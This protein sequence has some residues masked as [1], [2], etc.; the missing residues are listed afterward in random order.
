MMTERTMVNK[1]TLLTAVRPGQPVR[2][3]QVNGAQ[4]F[5]ARLCAMGLTPGAPVE[6]ACFS[7]GPVIANVMGGQ[8]MLG[9]GITAKVLVQEARA[10]PTES[11]FSFLGRNVRHAEPCATERTHR[12]D[13]PGR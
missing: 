12:R 4:R 13:R 10:R 1:M 5:G 11:G 7:G 6:V 8:L 2:V 3:S 9:R